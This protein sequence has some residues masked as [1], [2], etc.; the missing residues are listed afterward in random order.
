MDLEVLPT[1]WPWWMTLLVIVDLQ[2]SWV[3]THLFA[4]L[5]SP[6]GP[7]AGRGG[8]FFLGETK[9]R[10]TVAALG[11]GGQ[12]RVRSRGH[13]GGGCGV[14]FA[15]LAKLVSR[16]SWPWCPPPFLFQYHL[17]FPAPAPAPSIGFGH[18]GSSI[19]WVGKTSG[20]AVMVPPWS[21]E[22]TGG[23]QGFI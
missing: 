19:S 15:A 9:G 20:R 23:C 7:P 12:S 1:F 14:A 2:V 21:S 3:H 17:A 22:S 13:A 6:D 10:G 16:P 11:A 18:R 5:C 8:V 4:R